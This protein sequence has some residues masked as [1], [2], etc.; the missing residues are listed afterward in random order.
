M[1]KLPWIDKY[2]DRQGVVNK[3]VFSSDAPAFGAAVD[4]KAK[5]H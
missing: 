2:P 4:F 5:V 1:I 3:Q